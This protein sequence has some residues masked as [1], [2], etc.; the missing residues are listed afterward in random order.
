MIAQ[1]V[2]IGPRAA[3]YPDLKGNAN[4]ALL[5]IGA[6]LFWAAVLP[7]ASVFLAVAA[8][9]ETVKSPRRRRLVEWA[10]KGCV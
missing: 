7:L 1:L 4:E 10:G 8:L 5:L 3:K 9:C 2:H 6:T